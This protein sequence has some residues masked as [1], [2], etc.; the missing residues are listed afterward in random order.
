MYAKFDKST[1]DPARGDER[2]ARITALTEE[3]LDAIG[4]D[5]TREGLLRTPD[6]VGRAWADLT[7]GYDMT[8]SGAVGDALFEAMGSEMVIV[9]DIEVM[10]L[11]E[12]HLLP[13]YGRCHVA[14]L[15]S[16]KVVRISKVARIVDMF[17][18]RIQVQERLTTQ[19][20]EAVDE[21]LRP[22]GV[23]VVMDARHMCM[24]MRGVEKAHSTTVTSALL[25]RFRD[26]PATRSEFLSLV[27]A[28]SGV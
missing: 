2:I 9:R 4:E 22:H 26:N 5:R 25:G 8:L 19:I 10:S 12:H 7:K 3:L 21:V 16:D 23:G 6:R 13:F 15:P 28:R 18:K 14:Y 20:A 11:C 1:R 24:M 17:A 27:A